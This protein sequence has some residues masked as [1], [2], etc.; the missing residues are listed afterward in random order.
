MVLAGKVGGMGPG[1]LVPVL[2][3]DGLVGHDAAHPDTA[4]TVPAL[5]W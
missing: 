4:S 2:L 3:G 5:T 1:N